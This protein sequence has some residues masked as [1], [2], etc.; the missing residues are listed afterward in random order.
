MEISYILAEKG[1]DLESDEALAL[2]TV[3]G[4][5]G[6]FVPRVGDTMLYRCK[7]VPEEARNR[8]ITAEQLSGLYRVEEARLCYS[9]GL[10]TELEKNPNDLVMVG[11]DHPMPRIREYVL[12]GIKKVSE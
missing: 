1:K 11:E 9:G 2:F 7:T 5:N 12:C 10:E 3:R 4:E 6:L 8:D